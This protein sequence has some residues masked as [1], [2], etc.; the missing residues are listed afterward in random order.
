MSDKREFDAE[1]IEQYRRLLAELADELEDEVVPQL[2]DGPLRRVPAFGSAPGG[3]D[4]AAVEYASFHA[5]TWRN[6]QYLRATLRG[7]ESKLAG[8]T[9]DMDGADGDAA[10]DFA[11]FVFPAGPDSTRG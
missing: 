10:A 5:S 3:D 1:V 2:S 7:L 9:A 6:L 4:K 8:V 11:A